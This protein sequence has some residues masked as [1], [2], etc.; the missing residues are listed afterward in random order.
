MAMQQDKEFG[1]KSI[2]AYFDKKSF[3][4]CAVLK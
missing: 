2:E 4:A 1:L 3:D